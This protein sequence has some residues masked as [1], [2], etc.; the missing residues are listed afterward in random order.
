M[1]I[2]ALQSLRRKLAAHEPVHGLW[3]TLESAS[4]TEMAVALG[5]DWVV[6]DAEHGHLDWKQVL[7]HIRATVRSE[8]VALVRVAELNAG[9][10]KRALDIGADG[11]VVPWIETAEQLRQAVAFATYPPAGLRGAGAERATGWGQA[12][13][14][15][16]DEAAKVLV[17]PIIESVK[18]AENIE[19]LCQVPGV[20]IFQLGPADFSATAGYPGEW[21]G[22]GCA[23]RLLAVK[24]CVRRHGKHCGVLARNHDDLTLSHEQGFRF[25]GLG[26]DTAFFL[27]GLH[28]ALTHVGRDRSIRTSLAVEETPTPT[29]LDTVPEYMKP[30]RPEIMNRVDEAPQIEIDRGV[31]FRALVGSH[32][33]ARNLTTGIVTF[34]VDAALPY[35]THPFSESI[36]L[37]EGQATVE[38]EGRAY[39]LRPLDNVTIPRD[40]AHAVRNTSPDRPAIFHIAMASATPTRTAVSA[41][42]SRSAMADDA[43]GIAGKERVNRHERT[44]R[45][46]LAPRARFQDFFNRDLG[47]PDMS[48]GYGLFEP[49]A[50][51]PCH[52]HD[53]DESICIVSGTATCV[54]ESRR[55]SLT[56]NATALVPRGRC[57]YFI[58]ESNAPMAMIWVYAGPMPERILMNEKCCG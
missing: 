45:Y 1:K 19:T 22:P 11:V 12:F 38:V 17:V 30:D 14:Q 29:V 25:L 48:G 26:L 33:Q 57:H 44:P 51:L 28:A 7:E 24:D 52:L 4:L 41:A 50:R 18:G 23:E 27:R 56:G 10:I 3:V 31:L 8:T 49:G 20:D 13:R 47:C 15:H 37:L 58:N 46:E 16:V 43:A 36:T 55:Y 54:V 9:L 32:N 40:T 35:H 34:A 53:F 2:T 39:R 42:F 5:V 6:I 21:E